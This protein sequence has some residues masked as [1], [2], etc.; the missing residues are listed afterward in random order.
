MIKVPTTLDE[1]FALASVFEETM[2]HFNTANYR[3]LNTRNIMVKLQEIEAAYNCISNELMQEI[4]D[5][6]G[7]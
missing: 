4:K 2:G 3:G 5:F 6:K 1:Y 7:F